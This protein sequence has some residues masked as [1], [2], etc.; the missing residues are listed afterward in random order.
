M[1][2]AHHI[3]IIED[4]T[5]LLNAY[6]VK[7]S[8][9]GLDTALAQNAQEAYREIDKKVPDIIVLDLILPGEDG[10]N[11]LTKLRQ[12]KRTEKTPI[13]IVSNLGQPEDLDKA[14]EMGA[15]DYFIKSNTL[16]EVLLEKIHKY[17][18]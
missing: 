4:D 12:D 17:I 9:A 6:R 5:F 13:I 1:K 8:G 18:A 16:L 2:N 10:F 15:T 11:V 7:F 3:L 14:L